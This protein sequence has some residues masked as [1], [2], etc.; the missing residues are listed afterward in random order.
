M[1]NGDECGSNGNRQT[2]IKFE[3]N[4][5]ETKTEIDKVSE[6]STCKYEVILKTYLACNKTV[7][8]EDEMSMNVYPYLNTSLKSEWDNAYSDFVNNLITEKVSF[9]KF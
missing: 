4:Q 9:T 8:S 6:P 1:L 5:N 2:L 3:C 7:G